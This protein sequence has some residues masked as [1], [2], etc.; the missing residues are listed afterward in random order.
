M[1]GTCH[2]RPRRRRRLRG[3]LLPAFV[4]LTALVVGGVVLVTSLPSVDLTGRRIPWI[5]LEAYRTAASEARSTIDNCDIDWTVLAALGKVESDHGR[6]NGP[7]TIAPDG[8]VSPPIIGPALDGTH[9]TQA[10]H[11]TDRGRLDGD[12]V[13]DHAVGP[14]QFIP[15][16]WRELRRDGNGD[17]VKDPNNL[18][19]AALT[20]AAHLCLRE[21]GD[22]A[23]T[24]QLRR[25]LLAY[26]SSERYADDVLGWVERYRTVPPDEIALP[27]P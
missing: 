17:G 5:A 4:L 24:T 6:V 13:W 21:P 12:P 7:R 27:T 26:N 2:A 16:T 23:D 22:Y 8:T 11:D 10:I 15:T 19:D 9:G 3:S 20:A 18:F 14:M 25:A 1:P